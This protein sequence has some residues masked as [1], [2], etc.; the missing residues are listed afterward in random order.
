M[1]E[2][3]LI[4]SLFSGFLGL[5]RAVERAFDAET[6]WVSDIDKGACKVLAYRAPGVPN[7]GDITAVDWHKVQ[8]VDIITGG[9]PCQDIS[10][11]GRLAGMTE[12]TRSN[13]WVEMREA[14]RILQP[15]YVIW[16]NVRGAY[17]TAAHSAVE[18]GPRRVGGKHRGP[19]LRALGRVLGDLAALGFDAEWHG[20]RAADVGAPHGRFRVFVVASHPA[21]VRHEWSRTSRD[22]WA[23]PVNGGGE[24]VDLL[25]TPDANLG[26]GGRQRSAAALAVG[27]H[28]VNLS[29]LPRL[30]LGMPLGI[31]VQLLPTTTASDG[32]RVSTTY[33]RGNPTLVGA[34]LTT[35]RATRGGSSSETVQLLPTPSVADS[36]GGHERRGGKRGDELLLKG[37]ATHQ[38]WGKYA[39]A[40]AQ[41]EAIHGPAPAPTK[42]GRNG[43]P[44]LNPAF[45]EWM[46]GAPAGWITDVPGVTDNEAL[47]M[48]GNGVVEQQAY[49]AL[50]LMLDRMETTK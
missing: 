33:G 29:D 6:V 44:K 35:P 12:G 15:A 37:I 46:M 45:A 30:L 26:N 48:A 39:A 38:A 34:L 50:C 36:Q 27:A 8:P 17:S 23:G 7:L 42:P 32:E 49:A 41:W 20:L 25:P 28:Q 3:L 13:L 24:A 19:A 43:R 2:R 40:I 10:T 4:G 21:R 47:K 16:E 22:G 11:A 14:I 5:D 9:S 31:A 18:L 1:S